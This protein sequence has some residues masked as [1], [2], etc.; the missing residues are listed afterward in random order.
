MFIRGFIVGCMLTLVTGIYS[1][2]KS[3]KKFAKQLKKN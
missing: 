1:I 2:V 3:N